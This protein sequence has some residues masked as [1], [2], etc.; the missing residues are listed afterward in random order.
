[1][2]LHPT[3]PL[4]LALMASP[5]IAD[6]TT[7]TSVETEAGS[8]QQKA[9]ILPWPW[10]DQMANDV[11]D[12]LGADGEFDP[13]K[14]I[15]WGL[16]PGP[17]YSPEK[18]F[19]IGL[20]AV[21]LYIADDTMRTAAPS[22]ITVKG[23]GTSNGSVGA[24]I[25]LRSYRNHDR[26]RFY[27]DAEI[28]DAPDKYYGIGV[29]E[30]YI[31]HN[32]VEY[33]RTS[34]FIA[35]RYLW[36]VAKA[37]YAGIGIDYR[38][39][40]SDNLD[41]QYDQNRSGADG[42]NGFGR[43]S[44]NIALTGHWIH[45]SRDFALNASSG[46]LVDLSLG[47]YSEDFGSEEDFQKL[48]LNYSE[49]RA[50]AK[51]TLAWQLQAELTHGDVPWDQQALLGGSR[52]LRGYEEGRYRDNQLLMTQVEWRQ[53]IYGRHGAVVWAGAGTLADEVHELGDNKWLHT[54]GVGYR[55]AIKPKVNIRLDVGFGNSDKGVYF[56]VNEVF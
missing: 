40:D 24:E 53:P 14:G 42:R 54:V 51:G 4:A 7:D 18:E 5:A 36:H 23:Y 22:S 25:E 43:D 15:D 2:Q 27:L 9:K 34:Y 52:K 33:D 45:D 38:R 44:Q 17:I 50:I 41:P 47:V 35:P 20:S 3:L 6:H 46:R 28:A 11:L 55:F 56:S 26:E 16:V 32:E 37:T 1:M 19:G 21:G 10:A 30:G 13:D 49:Y 12:W 31:D 48:K 8:A 39:T 29:R